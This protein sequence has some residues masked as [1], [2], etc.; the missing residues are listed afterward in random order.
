[1]QVDGS[2][3][4]LG[5]VL[6]KTKLIYFSFKAKRQKKALILEGWRIDVIWHEGIDEGCEMKG[7][8]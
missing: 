8:K 7:R 1:M 2:N 6:E 5:N 4:D 3:P